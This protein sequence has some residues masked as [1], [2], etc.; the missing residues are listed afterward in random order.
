MAKQKLN[1]YGFH[2]IGPLFAVVFVAVVGLAGYKVFHL[3]DNSKAAGEAPVAAPAASSDIPAGWQMFTDKNLGAQFLYPNAFGAF[4]DHN[5][6][7]A[8]FPDYEALLTSAAP[9]NSG[10]LGVKNGFTLITYK[11]GHDTITTHTYGPKIKLTDT[12]WTVVEPNPYNP[13][14]YK[15]GDAYT[16][17]Q[18]ANKHG[19]PVYWDTSA[20]EGTVSYNIYFMSNNR[21]H[22]LQLPTFDSG[23]YDSNNIVDQGP[24]DAMFQTVRDSLALY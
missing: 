11:K 15:P 6:A 8:S 5:E 23:A 7:L 4:T 12:G 21:L 18:S 10:I 3:K 16:D 22:Q 9:Q 1:Q 20:D 19:L 17:M 13:K 24:Y 2:V 14:N